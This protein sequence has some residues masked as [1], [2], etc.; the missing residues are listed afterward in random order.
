MYLSYA[1]RI[2]LTTI[3][4]VL[5]G[6]ATAAT[7]AFAPIM[8]LAPTSLLLDVSSTGERLVAVGERGHILYSDDRGDSWQQARVPTTQ[9]LTSV[10]FIDDKHGWAAGHDGLILASDD[11][12]SSWRIQR[13]GIAAQQQANL[14]QREEAYRLREQLE[15]ELAE[16]GVE[17]LAQLELALEDAEM[18]LE[19]ADLA[20]AEPPFASPLLDIWFQNRER[21]WAIGA[22]G[23]LLSTRDGGS[24]WASEPHAI[25]NPDELHLNAITGDGLG[26]ALIAGESGLLF[27]SMDGG[28]T[29]E[30][31]KTI[32]DGSWF[33]ALY[34]S[35]S[36]ALLVFG[37]RGQLYRSQ[38]FGLQWTP[39]DSGFEM[40][41]A[42]GSASPSGEMV[43]VGSVGAV[44]HSADGGR[45]F[46]R[47]ILADRL[48]LSSGLQQGERLI[49]VGQ[50]GVRSLD[51]G[52]E[53]D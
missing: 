36:K 30:S 23:T 39:L 21:G 37:L 2:A 38:D 14:E 53:H 43:I 18:D 49:L 34:S 25:D 16:A 3:C 27:R 51:A 5:A 50:G 6:P 28:N 12:G 40:T 8:P 24:H 9:M 42:G 1:L 41:L 26:R 35:T 19:D 33:G 48:S 32:Y 52:A 17:Q 31:L 15:L 29:W 7:A 11:A 45:S 13:D 20:L 10:C 46:Q 44:L 22:F 47:R 4:I